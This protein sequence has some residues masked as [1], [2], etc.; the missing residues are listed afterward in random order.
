MEGPVFDLLGADD[1]A[2][3]IVFVPVALLLIG[4]GDL[5]VIQRGFCQFTLAV[6]EID[7]RLRQQIP[8]EEFLLH[9]AVK[10]VV[11]VRR[12]TTHQCYSFFKRTMSPAIFGAAAYP[13]KVK[14]AKS[15]LS[16]LHKQQGAAI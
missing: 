9:Q 11:L 14:A 10:R 5:S 16:R 2:Q 12:G 13:T 7:L 15:H 1:A 3:G 8:L 4:G 6:V